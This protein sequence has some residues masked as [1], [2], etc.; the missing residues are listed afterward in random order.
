M[1]GIFLPR[2]SY[3]YNILSWFV[4]YI[5]ISYPR[6]TNSWER[7]SLLY[8]FYM[9]K[10]RIRKK[11]IFF[12]LI[13]NLCVC[14]CVC[15]FDHRTVGCVSMRR[16]ENTRRGTSVMFRQRTQTRRRR[17]IIFWSRDARGQEND[18]C[19]SACE[20]RSRE[21]Q[22]EKI[23]TQLFIPCRY[24]IKYKTQTHALLLYFHLDYFVFMRFQVS[25]SDISVF[26]SLCMAKICL[27]FVKSRFSKI[28]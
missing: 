8:F 28:E 10:K 15:Q 18:K 16:G 19:R 27:K 22:N 3:R 24:N 11:N 4:H 1:T 13:R 14:V 5:I 7:L 20:S 12:I 23:H 25:I 9:K 21:Q 17:Y 26:Y 6:N 2:S